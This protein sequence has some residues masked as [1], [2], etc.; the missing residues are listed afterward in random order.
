MHVKLALSRLF[1]VMFSLVALGCG[2]SAHR[3]PVVKA[4]AKASPLARPR[5]PLGTNI[6]AVVD[7]SREIAFVD[8]FKMS[9]EWISG[10]EGAWDD[11]RPLELDEHG[12]VKRLM[13]GQVART[14]LF[15]Y[16]GYPAYPAGEYVV[17]YQGEGE[18]VY[19]AAAEVVSRAP[20]RD[21]IRLDPKKGGLGINLM[22]T[23]P[24]NYL[25]DIHVRALADENSKALFT[26]AFLESLQGFAAV[27]FMDWA[28]INESPP[29]AF[30]A[31]PRVDDARYSTTRGVPIEVMLELANQAQVDPW[32]CVPYWADDAWVRGQA[33][34]VKQKLGKDRKVYVEHANEVWNSMFP[35]FHHALAQARANPARF[36]GPADEF[37]AL[38]NYHAARSAQIFRIWE[39]VFKS[40]RGRLVRVFGAWAPVEWTSRNPLAFENSRAHVDAVAIAPY[41]GAEL[42]GPEQVERVKKLT[43]DQLLGELHEKWIPESLSW[44]RQHHANTAAQGLSLIA[45][46]GGQHLVAVGPAMEDPTLNQLFDA[47]NA[48]P[49]MEG[50]YLRYL[51]GWRA[52]GGE[53]FMNFSS[54]GEPSKFGRWG[55]RP[56]LIQPRERFPK[57]RALV[58]FAAKN[59]RWW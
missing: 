4:K 55:T 6:A 48:D 53:L 11:A 22:R 59:P 56:D 31:R 8:A 25:R 38:M 28:R 58:E 18:L 30:A 52:A 9:R 37:G 10:H 32:L 49:R 54:V 33:E 35:A 42:G 27:R 12:W 57:A 24:E 15:W 50:L 21:I 41:F 39:E 45:Y 29:G 2:S 5:S 14:L 40:E 19:F 23:R 17:T 16:D 51:Q 26:R 46:E 44:V 20:G 47:V 3:P 34:L 7:W 1:L 13:P 36:G 43:V